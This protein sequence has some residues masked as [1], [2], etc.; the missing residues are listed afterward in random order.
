MHTDRGSKRL[1][2]AVSDKR[3]AIAVKNMLEQNVS[4]LYPASIL[5][6][7]K[8]CICYLDTFSA[9]LISQQTIE[10]YKA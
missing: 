2:Q 5:Q 6:L 1:R 10:K 8:N 3:K 9:S 7:H 4:D